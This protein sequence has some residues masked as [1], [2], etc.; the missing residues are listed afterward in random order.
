MTRSSFL[1]SL[2]AIAALAPPVAVSDDSREIAGIRL[3]DSNLA[4][5]AGAIA[6]SAEPAEIFNH[7]LRTFLFAEL[8]AKAKGIAHDVEIVYVASIM[9]DLGM[10]SKYISAENPF[11]VDGANAAKTLLAK[12]GLPEL[13]KNLAWD[14][15]A[16][17][18]NS[19][20]ARHKQ[21]EVALVNMGVGADFGGFLDELKEEDV[22]RVL[23]AAPRTNFVETFMGAA[24]VIAQRKP[25]ACAHSF[26][27][28]IGYCKVPGFSLPSFC[29]AVKHDPFAKYGVGLT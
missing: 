23:Q 28:D 5:E 7:S 24:A 25:S 10:S 12:Y 13:R 27:A 1:N 15:I 26:V 14:A 2:C 20:I 22:M 21:P 17:H 11:E 3:P 19:G 6:R 29:D 4:R 8:V 18:D 16:L 9:H